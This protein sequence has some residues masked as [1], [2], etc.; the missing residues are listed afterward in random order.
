MKTQS[1]IALAVVAGFGLG[2]LSIHMLHAQGK[3]PGRFG[4]SAANAMRATPTTL[5]PGR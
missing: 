4:F 3:P 2:S 1:S 5:R